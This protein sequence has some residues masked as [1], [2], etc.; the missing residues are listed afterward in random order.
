[1][2]R[3]VCTFV[4]VNMHAGVRGGI[5]LERKKKS[6]NRRP[7]RPH[8]RCG[9]PRNSIYEMLGRPMPRSKSGR[10]KKSISENN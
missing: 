5:A 7:R 2:R 3:G 1:M 8:G 10:G 6:P 4:S 9:R